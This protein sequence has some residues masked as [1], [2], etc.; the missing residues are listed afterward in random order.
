MSASTISGA[1]ASAA[2]QVAVFGDP[3]PLGNGIGVKQMVV[4][5]WQNTPFTFMINTNDQLFYSY[6]TTS[7]SFVGHLPAG[8]PPDPKD[9]TTNYTSW[10][11][12]TGAAKQISVDLWNNQ[13]YLYLINSK[14]ELYYGNLYS[15]STAPTATPEAAFSGW[16]FVTGAAKQ[17]E[18]N[19]WGGSPYLYLI[20]SKDELYFGNLYT[21]G[22]TSATPGRTAF[23]GWNFITGAAKQIEADPWRNSDYLYLIN[24]KDELYYGNLYF[25]PATPGVPTGRASFSGWNFITGA[26][27]DVTVSQWNGNPYLYLINSKD[28]LYYGNLAASST[29]TTIRPG[30]SA[31]SGWSFLTGAAKNV[32]VNQWNGNAYLYL[33]NSKDELYYGSLYTTQAQTAP[34]TFTSHTAFTGWTF[35]TGAAKRVEV[36]QRESHPFVALVNSKNDLYFGNLTLARSTVYPWSTYLAFGGW[37]Q[38]WTDPL[39]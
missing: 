17:V 18:V 2:N 33:I 29:S 19:D 14:D 37:I 4:V 5:N 9:I 16:N 8:S 26:A 38:G 24:S 7:S 13:P 31:F 3:P 32:T 23:S 11:F 30:P 20:N 10:K 6:P 34:L 27:K 22:P 25:D 39:S 36:G 35:L 21:G 1:V 12:V 15:T 28:E